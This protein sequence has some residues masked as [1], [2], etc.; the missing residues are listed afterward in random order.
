M[1]TPVSWDEVEVVAED[2]DPDALK[3]DPA[4]VLARVEESGDLYAGSLAEDQELPEL[5]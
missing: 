3:F 4:A 5:T 2:G 1:S